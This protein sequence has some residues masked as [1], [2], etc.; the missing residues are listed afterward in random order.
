MAKTRPPTE[1]ELQGEDDQ[2]SEYQQEVEEPKFEA[3]FPHATR[4]KHVAGRKSAIASLDRQSYERMLQYIRLG[5]FCHV[6][7][8][9][10]GVSNQTFWKWMRKGEFHRK[11]P[12]RRFYLDV[13][14]AQAE[15]RMLAEVEVRKMDPR[16]WLSKGPG[17]TK[18]GDPGWTDEIHQIQ[19]G[20]QGMEGPGGHGGNQAPAT[21]EDAA[22]AFQVLEQI[23]V[24]QRTETGRKLFEGQVSGVDNDGDEGLQESDFADGARDGGGD[25]P[26]LPAVGD[27]PPEHEVPT[28]SQDNITVEQ[29]DDTPV[30]PAPVLESGTILDVESTDVG[31][32]TDPEESDGSATMPKGVYDRGPMLAKRAKERK[33]AEKAAGAKPAKSAKK[34][35][36]KK[37]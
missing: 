24:V 22:K 13:C 25:E 14:H 20:M 26:G 6:A 15:A 8:Q 18:P 3:A 36:A 28:I 5:A 2:L 11:G 9:S 12:Y 17:K 31:E 29:V 30:S 1:E 7:A 35:A 19:G 27:L 32:P 4:S 37:K 23:G 33:A 21:L 10:L 34:K 16:F